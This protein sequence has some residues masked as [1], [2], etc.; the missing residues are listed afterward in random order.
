MDWQSFKD[1]LGFWSSL[2]TI[3]TALIAVFCFCFIR[4]RNVMN[5]L[6]AQEQTWETGLE[7]FES[8]GRTV[9]ARTDLGI[10]L[11]SHLAALDRV[12]A[13]NQNIANLCLLGSWVA[14]VLMAITSGS[15][16]TAIVYV[17]G[18]CVLVSFSGAVFYTLLVFRIA[19]YTNSLQQKIDDIWVGAIK[20]HAARSVRGPQ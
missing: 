14:T 8:A 4:I 17:F 16:D 5:R 9:S 19:R 15:P 12:R 10:F 6:K 1:G 2:A 13:S 18:F 20:G 7:V 11:L 3:C